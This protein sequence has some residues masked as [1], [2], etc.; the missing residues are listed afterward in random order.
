M[1]EEPITELKNIKDLKYSPQIAGVSEITFSVPKT[2]MDSRGKQKQNYLYD[3]IEGNFMVL[4]NDMEYFILKQPVEAIDSNG[5]PVKSITGYSREYEL[6]NKILMGYEGV[7][8][9]IYDTTDEVDENGLQIGFLNYVEKVS[10]W[11]VGYV[12]PEI[13]HKR[14]MLSFPKTNILQSFQEIQEIFDCLLSFNTKDKVIDVLSIDQLGADN[15]LFLTDENYIDELKKT[16]DDDSIVTRLYLYGQNNISIQSLTITGQPYIENYNYFMKEKYMSKELIDGLNEYYKYI[17]GKE[18]EFQGLLKELEP[19]DKLKHELDTTSYELSLEKRILE[20]DWDDNIEDE[21]RRKEIE[22]KIAD[23]ESKIDAND[24][25]KQANNASIR[26]VNA[27]I[28]DIRVDANLNN[29]IGNELVEELDFFIQEDAYIDN[30]FHEDNLEELLE[31]GE[32]NLA[33]VSQ[34][35]ITFDIDLFDFLSIIEAK[36]L[37]N[38]LVLG[39]MVHIE[40]TQLDEY[41]RVKLIGY[42]H[43]VDG[44]IL[45]L[46]FSSMDSIFSNELYLEEVLT[47]ASN[48]ASVVDFNKFNWN[49]I[50]VVQNDFRDYIQHNLDLSNQALT[51][52]EGQKPILDDRGLWLY[53]ENPDGTHSP[54]QIRAINNIIAVTKDDWKTVDVAITPEGV[55]ANQ[56]IG[57]IILGTNLKIVSNSG[58]VEILENLLTIRD[59]EGRIR[60]QLGKYEDDKYGL[61]VKDKEGNKTILDEDGMLQVWQE[62][63]TDNVDSR[64]PL[65]LRVFIPPNTRSL[66]D[67]RLSYEV[68]QFRSYSGTTDTGGAVYDTTGWEGALYGTAGTDGAVSTTSGGGG[69]TYKPTGL[70]TD[71]EQGW[72]YTS[73]PGEDHEHRYWHVTHHKHQIDIADHH[74]SIDISGHSHLVYVEGHDH[75]VEIGG[76]SHNI[77]PII[78]KSGRDASEIRIV[79]NGVDRTHAIT[80]RAT[81][82]GD[83]ENLDI[84]EYL[85]TG[86]MNTVNIYSGNLGRIDATIFIQALLNFG[87]K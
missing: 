45:R 23:V 84:T 14:R 29:H 54:E 74:H 68:S 63:R 86:I 42:E 4:V 35:A 64:H 60:V 69:G 27:R 32:K 62:G 59:D 19:L 24:V 6:R 78:S 9:A 83:K 31:I 12:S 57:D 81:N 75:S 36:P 15:G 3:T 33:K 30:N 22:E 72:Q 46:T 52:A 51:K 11:K 55:M 56:L 39:D 41:F 70:A 47:Q 48:A 53:K 80:G 1:D 44:Q 79:I 66:Y 10:S 61:L 21:I 5:E 77:L 76:H 71:V 49:E 73:T 8:R 67:V 16:T 65:E 58:V 37:W 13:I 85:V 50:G 87:G 20:D 43:D 82:N 7:S 28:A 26:E 18:G 17:D 34:P 25:K 38:K 40:H 2:I